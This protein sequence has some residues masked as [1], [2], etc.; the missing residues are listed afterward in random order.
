MAILAIVKEVKDTQDQI[1]V[2]INTTMEEIKSHGVTEKVK[3][4]MS[5]LLGPKTKFEF[6]TIS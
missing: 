1:L 2:A 4:E 6:K 5:K 3:R